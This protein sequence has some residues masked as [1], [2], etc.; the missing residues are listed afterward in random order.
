MRAKFLVIFFI[1]VFCLMFPKTLGV[2]LG[3]ALD[4]MLKLLLFLTPIFFV[5]IVATVGLSI[6]LG[7]IR[8]R[9]N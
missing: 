1:I 7:E 4:N 5:L 8:K 6:I 9:G 2:V 3:I